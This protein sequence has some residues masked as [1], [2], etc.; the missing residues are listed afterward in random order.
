MESLHYLLMKSHSVMQRKIYSEAQKIGLTSGQPK[1]LD[2][3]YEHEG[4]DQK[5]IAGYCEIEPATLGS[6]L[7]RME[8][9]G[10]IE[11]RQK[12]GNRRSWFVY[13][14][15]NGKEICEKMHDIF[16]KADEQAIE[17]ISPVEIEEIKNLLTKICR[18]LDRK[19]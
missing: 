14:T 4:S 7:L 15:E 17:N 5:T 8:Q 16:S 10:L 9:K 6:I 11:R 13:L 12:N 18:N 2:Y 19:D 1:I 3:L